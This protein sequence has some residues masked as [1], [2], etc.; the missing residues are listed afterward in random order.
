MKDKSQRDLY[1]VA[2]KVFL[3]NKG[4]LF[5]FRDRWGDWDIPGG[6]IQKREFNAPLEK[7]I[8]RKMEEELGR[9]VRYQLG[10]PIVF[11]RHERREAILPNR[12]KVKIFAIGY[13]AKYLGGEIKLSMEHTQY[14]WVLIKRL[15]PEKYFKGGWLKGVKEYLHI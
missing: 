11:M 7:I 9:T 4:K 6:R 2:V 5:I 8:K 15:K 10:K 12:P 1:Y 3:E 13:Q 14:E